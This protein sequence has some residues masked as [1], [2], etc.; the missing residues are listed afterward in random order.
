MS[1]SPPRIVC[2]ANRYTVEFGGHVVVP[3]AR[4]FDRRMRALINLIGL[5]GRGEEQGFIDQHGCFYTR[6]E[7]WPVAEANGQIVKRVG[8]DGPDHFGLFSE[9]LY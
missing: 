8:G 4:H 9:N 6:M 3:S 2:A 1:L 7:A 5:R